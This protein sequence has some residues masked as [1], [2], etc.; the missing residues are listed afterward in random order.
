MRPGNLAADRHVHHR[1]QLP[2][3]VTVWITFAAG[4]PPSLILRRTPL[5]RENTDARPMPA[6]AIIKMSAHITHPAAL[7][8]RI[9]YSAALSPMRRARAAQV[10][11]IPA[12]PRTFSLSRPQLALKVRAR[13]RSNTSPPPNRSTTRRVGWPWT[14]ADEKIS[15]SQA[16]FLTA[17][18]QKGETP[19]GMRVR[20]GPA[21]KIVHAAD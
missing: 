2:S 11:A 20:R 17:F 5:A 8:C 9:S 10:T 12:C 19:A 7:F 3:P 18:A 14:L 1:V 21:R 13:K 6:P 4:P 16:G 15:G